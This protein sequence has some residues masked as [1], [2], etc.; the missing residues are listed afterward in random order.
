MK[1]MAEF[2]VEER[3][4]SQL[5]GDKEGK[6]LGDSIRKVHLGV[7]DARF[8]QI[9]ELQKTLRASHGEPFFYGWHIRRKY[10]AAELDAAKLF[11]MA[12]GY[13]LEPAGEDCGTTYDETTGCPECGAGAAQTSDLWLD[14]RK[15]PKSRDLV[16]TIADEVIVSQRLAERMIEAGL[17]GFRFGRVHHKARYQ[18]DAMDFHQTPSGRELLQRAEAAGTPLSDPRFWVW[19]NRAE[20]RPLSD[21]MTAEHVSM[22]EGEERRNPKSW[23]VWHQLF[24]TSPPVDIVAPTRVGIDPFN[25]DPEGE[26]RC[27]RGD[28]IG[29]NRLSEL[30]VAANQLGDADFQPT[31]QFVGVHRGLLRP[32]QLILISPRVRK[33]LK[34][35]GIRA[36]V[37]LEVAHPV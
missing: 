15:A 9:G 34:S 6:R 28:L 27:S 8:P 16:A 22:K 36:S 18:D 11:L 2:R 17:T 21:A 30:S 14:L 23:P 7:D 20:N 10:D 35:E 3:F 19:L 29:L 1:E 24:V 37:T 32:R 26:C 31:R 13:G 12:V 25:S 5:F 4:A 33:L